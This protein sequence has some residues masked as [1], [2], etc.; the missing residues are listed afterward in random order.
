METEFSCNLFVGL[1][2][3]VLLN[4]VWHILMFELFIYLLKFY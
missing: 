3:I 1:I 2:F 4:K